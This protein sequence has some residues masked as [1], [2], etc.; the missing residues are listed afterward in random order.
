MNDKINE[1]ISVLEEMF[2]DAFCELNF[3]DNFQLLIAVMLSA[4]TTD[5]AVNKVTEVLFR[6]YPTVEDI[7]NAEVDEIEAIIKRLGLYKN[8]AKNIKGISKVIY[9]EYDGK[10]VCDRKVLESLPG[11]GRKTTNVVMSV[12]F[13]VPAFAVDTHVERIAKRLKLAYQKDSVYKVEE[14]LRRK[15][16]EETWNKLHHQL[17]FFGRYF[18]TARKPKCRECKLIKYCRNKTTIID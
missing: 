12:G 15:F 7:Y 17:I 11:V 9:E 13:D 14:K 10:I 1:I 2:P 4:Q 5:K 6:E 8:K 16:P 18:C 3:N